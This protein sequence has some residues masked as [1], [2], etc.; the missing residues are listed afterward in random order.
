MEISIINENYCT[1]ADTITKLETKGIAMAEA[2]ELWEEV[3]S[4]L[5]CV[6]HAQIS[7][8][9]DYIVKKKS[10]LKNLIPK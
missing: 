8:K 5:S 3:I 1:I 2:V 7:H 9:T 10:E 4:H 6:N